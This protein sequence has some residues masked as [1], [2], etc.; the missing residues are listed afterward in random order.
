MNEKKGLRTETKM[1]EEY[2]ESSFD[3][4]RLE[5]VVY[6]CLAGRYFTENKRNERRGK[7]I[8]FQ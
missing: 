7:S 8:Y 4:R 2:A 1:G 3:H 5:K 6:L